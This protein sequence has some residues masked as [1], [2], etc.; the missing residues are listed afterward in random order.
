MAKARKAEAAPTEEVRIKKA[1]LRTVQFDLIGTT[2]LVVR[3]FSEKIK[4][5]LAGDQEEGKAS[6]SK[7]KR[8]PRSAEDDFNDA[9]YISKEG[10]DGFNASGLRNALISACRLVGYKMTLAKL[11]I[12]V[13]ADGWDKYEP[14]IPLIK[15]I[16]KPIMQTD[17]LLTTTKRPYIGARPA[18]HDWK[19]KV[20]IR[21]D[22]DQF[23]LTDV[24]NLLDRVGA[25]VGL[26]EGR[27]D[28]KQSCG[29]GWGCFVIGGQ[30]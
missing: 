15:I 28:S 24:A 26:G 14:Q 5:E 27:Y 25:Q 13:L 7:K 2:P 11:S 6:G 30:K 19:A 9:R 16:G 29:M 10:W 22:E 8:K 3:R 21:W 18:Y 20:S 17:R 1:R 4:R 23:S 12:F